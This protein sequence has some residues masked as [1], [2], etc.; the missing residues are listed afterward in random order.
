[1][2]IKSICKRFLA[3]LI[4]AVTLS[5]LSAVNVSAEE[6]I[7]LDVLAVA[8]GA[9]TDYLNFVNFALGHDFSEEIYLK[10]KENL[11]P[12]ERTSY[13]DS[14]AASSTMGG[15]CFG[16]S[17]LEVLTHN[18]YISPSQ[19]QEGAEHLNDIIVDADVKDL[20]FYYHSM[21]L[22]KNI[23]Y[24]IN[25][26]LC[27][28]N[29]EDDCRNLAEHAEK[30]MEDSRYFIIAFKVNNSGHAVACIGAADG[31]WEFK[32]RTYDKCI[33]TIDSNASSLDANGGR[34]YAGFSPKIC[35]YVNTKD[36]EYYIPAY[37]VGSFDGSMKINC[38]LDNDALLNDGSLF[39]PENAEPYESNIMG[40]E[41]SV[42]SKPYT[43][44]AYHD[45]V[46]T[47]YYGEGQKNPGISKGIQVRGSYVASYTDMKVDG[48]RLS[49]DEKES[50]SLNY[51]PEMYIR[52]ANTHQ[53]GRAAGQV[54]IDIRK[55]YI[56]IRKKSENTV[57]DMHLDSNNYFDIDGSVGFDL[58]GFS[59]AENLSMEYI[60]GEGLLL[61]TDGEVDTVLAYQRLEPDNV[62]DRDDGG[63][64]A[65]YTTIFTIFYYDDVML[66]YDKEA[67]FY[68]PYIDRD[69]DGYFEYKVQRGDTNCDGK[70]DASDASNI[71]ISYARAQTGTFV[72]YL[73]HENYGD[74][75]QDGM[76]DASDASAV[77]AEYSRLSTT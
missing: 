54:E 55:D 20:L 13:L 42:K 37:D 8:L 75:N 11:T 70:I 24:E 17:A 61:K 41:T 35:I 6:N 73:L 63:D 1:M 26:Y 76:I 47:V 7:D 60:Q 50:T 46:E 29:F 27:N 19:L 30:A 38:I 16:I 62:R 53:Y 34:Y 10:Y 33:L 56:G 45:G 21:Q 44:T 49:T 14:W 72:G 2:G 69:D 4:A 32:G 25:N 3:T 36:S 59:S 9:D 58:D 12:I 57:F 18:G 43:L 71:L 51:A 68:I 77:L 48:W 67:N 39:A 40:I 66:K 65:L 64:G 5:T 15:L 52:T 31:N 23:Q 28:N 74:Y 22:H